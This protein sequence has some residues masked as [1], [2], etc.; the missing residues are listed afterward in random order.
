M[1]LNILLDRVVFDYIPF[2]VP[3]SN[4]LFTNF[5]KYTHNYGQYDGVKQNHNTTHQNLV[6]LPFKEWFKTVEDD[7]CL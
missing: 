5:A 2:L 3:Y 4:F 7:P 1:S 6:L